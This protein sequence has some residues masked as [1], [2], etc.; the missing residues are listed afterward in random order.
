M[1]N[2]AK[3]RVSLVGCGRIAAAH[4]QALQT[5]EEVKLVG[6]ADV[7]TAAR[8]A[9]GSKANCPGYSDYREMIDAQKPEIVVVCVPPISHPEVTNY[10]LE[11]GSHVLCEKPFA[12]DSDSALGMV[13]CAERNKRH[14]TMASKFRFVE[15]VCKARE[16]IH[17][18]LIGK[19]VLCEIAFCARADMRGRW[20]SNPE[21]S[22]GGVLIDNG[23]HAVDI[24]RFLLGPIRRV[25]AQHGR[26][27]QA[28]RVEDTAMVFVETADGV[29]GRID[30]SWSIE[31]NHDA[32]ICIHGSEGMIV[33]GWASSRHRRYDTKEWTQFGNG[34][35]KLS[36]FVLQHRNFIDCTYGRAKPVINAEDSLESVRVIEMAYRSAHA[37]KWLEVEE[38]VAR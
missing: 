13:Q 21:I 27:I 34:Y 26:N 5:I 10:A 17:D 18:G 4:L 24:I 2:S 25:Q 37:N 1:S 22:G 28:L 14:L 29:W 3:T 30:L 32:F 11:R 8:D 31:K 15:D 19:M 33:V 38:W 35:N 36:A 6:A 9:F 16:M 12:I 7:D 23:S 20:P